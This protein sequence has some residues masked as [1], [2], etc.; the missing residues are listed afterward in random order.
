M[1]ID[2]LYMQQE[3]WAIRMLYMSG[4]LSEC[5]HHEGVYIENGEDVE[6]AYKYAMRAFKNNMDDSPFDEVR[7]MTDAIKRSYEEHGGNDICPL[8]FGR[9][10][11]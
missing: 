6:S 4:V 10:H 9:G 7:E 11:D 5:V 3:N 8:C 2:Q 1:S